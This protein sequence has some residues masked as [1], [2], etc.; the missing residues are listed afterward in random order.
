[1]KTP[2]YH[3]RRQNSDPGPL[4]YKGPNAHPSNH[5]P[6]SIHSCFIP[7][8]VYSH[9][10]LYN[11]VSYPLSEFFRVLSTFSRIQSVS[12]RHVLLWTYAIILLLKLI[13]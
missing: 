12:S 10:L 11:E 1:M 8:R 6:N 9:F 13:I 5:R 7:P 4:S 3:F 2:Y